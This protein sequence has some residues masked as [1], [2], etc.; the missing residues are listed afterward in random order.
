MRTSECEGSRTS[1]PFEYDAAVPMTDGRLGKHMRVD[2]VSHC[3]IASV[4]RVLMIADVK[5]T[6]YLYALGGMPPRCKRRSGYPR[7]VAL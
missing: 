5:V 1:S 6:T 7:S 2:R 4:V 3:A